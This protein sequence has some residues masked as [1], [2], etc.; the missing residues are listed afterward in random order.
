M[1]YW[2]AIKK[3]KIYVP[4]IHTTED[5]RGSIVLLFRYFIHNSN[6]SDI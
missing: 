3:L 1:S 4:Q 2:M 6:D 5:F